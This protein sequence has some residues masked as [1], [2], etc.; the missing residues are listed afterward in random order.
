MTYTRRELLRCLALG[1]M[2]VAGGLWLPGQT[3][4]FIPAPLKPKIITLDFQVVMDDD[5]EIDVMRSK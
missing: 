4:I 5:G 2:V 3:K 1:G